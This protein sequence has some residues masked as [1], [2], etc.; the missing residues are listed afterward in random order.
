MVI[1]NLMCCFQQQNFKSQIQLV[2]EAYLN[3]SHT[4]GINNLMEKYYFG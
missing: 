4:V 2:P 1:S 3:A